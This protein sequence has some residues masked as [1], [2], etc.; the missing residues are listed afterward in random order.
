[1]AYIQYGEKKK[2]MEIHFDISAKGGKWIKKIINQLG[3]SV[4]HLQS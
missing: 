4:S 2:G 1:M 3:V